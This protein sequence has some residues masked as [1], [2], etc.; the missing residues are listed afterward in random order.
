MSRIFHLKDI[1]PLNTV[2]KRGNSKQFKAHASSEA[3]RPKLAEPPNGLAF[4]MGRFLSA[5]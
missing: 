3:S 1:Y 5:S 2:T 4:G